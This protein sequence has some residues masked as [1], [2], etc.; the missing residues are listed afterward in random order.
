MSMESERLRVLPRA[1]AWIEIIHEEIKKDKIEGGL[2]YQRA[3]IALECLSLRVNT[4]KEL[5][6]E[7]TRSLILFLGGLPNDRKRKT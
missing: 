4:S 6:K 3:E 7:A 1:T 5:K 2:Y